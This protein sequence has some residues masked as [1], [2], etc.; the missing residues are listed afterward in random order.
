M[1]DSS[2]GGDR[3]HDTGW[4]SAVHPVVDI[5]GTPEGWVEITPEEP[6]DLTKLDGTTSSA[7][8]VYEITASEPEY[9]AGMPRET[10]PEPTV[11]EPPGTEWDDLLPPLDY[12]ILPKPERQPLKTERSAVSVS[13]PPVRHQFTVHGSQEIGMGV[14]EK[15]ILHVRDE[16]G[17][18]LTLLER[19]VKDDPAERREHND[20]YIHSWQVCNEAGIPVVPE[21]MVSDDDTLLVTDVKAG[22][23]EVYGKGMARALSSYDHAQERHRPHA[24]IDALFMQI[25][26]P[27]NV[28]A[29]RAEA[30]R[31]SQLAINA[32]MELP[33]DDPYEL[34]VHPDGTWQLMTLD[35]DLAIHTEPERLNNGVLGVRLVRNNREASDYLIFQLQKIRGSLHKM[36]G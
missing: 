22:G 9:D 8:P 34:I 5:S 30:E 6:D 18:E 15:S 29:I 13:D 12:A 2:S 3:Q 26:A 20:H 7:D 31:I 14:E 10:P 35:L 23:S 19:S 32:G 25:T 36:S 21:V 4:L 33:A 28:G 17:R 27:E 11:P 16:E 1:N 24:D